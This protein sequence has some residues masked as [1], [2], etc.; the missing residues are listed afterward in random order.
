MSVG[1]IN[2]L[3]TSSEEWIKYVIQFWLKSIQAK[4]IA[5][6]RYYN[7]YNLQIIY[8]IIILPNVLLQTQDPNLCE[9]QEQVVYTITERIPLEEYGRFAEDFRKIG[10]IG[11]IRSVVRKDPQ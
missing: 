8:L 7:M 1:Y 4:I 9:R 2:Q 10:I 6:K 5:P 11:S 3:S